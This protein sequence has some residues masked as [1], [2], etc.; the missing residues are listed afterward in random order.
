MAVAELPKSISEIGLLN[1]ITVLY[2]PSN[3]DYHYELIA[4][5]HRLEFHK[6]L[7]R[8][9]IEANI[10]PPHKFNELHTE[11]A[12]IDENLIRAE[13]YYVDKGDL[14]YRRKAIYETLY[15]ESKARF[16]RAYVMNKALGV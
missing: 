16:K 15:P 14:L 7:G 5:R 2:K 6:L 13:L 11:L 3:N 9:E 10:L 1:P 8:T 12:E 4:G